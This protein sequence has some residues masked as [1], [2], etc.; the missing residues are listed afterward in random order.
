MAV[1]SARAHDFTAENAKFS[2]LA[3]SKG[4]VSPQGVAARVALERANADVEQVT[5]ACC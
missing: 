4:M 1:T 2:S 5:F 3:A